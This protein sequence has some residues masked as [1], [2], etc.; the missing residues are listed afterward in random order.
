MCK[1]L[2]EFSEFASQK[3]ECNFCKQISEIEPTELRLNALYV[4]IY[5]VWMKFFL[6]EIIPYVLI[7]VLNVIMIIR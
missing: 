7:F 2:T 3:S 5:V 6:V 4:Q 1:I